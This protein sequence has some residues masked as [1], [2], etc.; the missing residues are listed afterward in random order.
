MTAGPE[1]PR[2]QQGAER[3]GQDSDPAQQGVPRVSLLRDSAKA[4]YSWDHGRAGPSG[5]GLPPL[6]RPAQAPQSVPLPLGL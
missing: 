1:R 6:L 4:A 5:R 3:A 2:T